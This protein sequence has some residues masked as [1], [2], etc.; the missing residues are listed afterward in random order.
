[1]IFTN[2]QNNNQ[3]PNKITVYVKN[4]AVKNALVANG[5][6]N[7][8][9]KVMDEIDNSGDI[10]GSMTDGADTVYVPAGNYTFPSSSVTEGDTIVCAPGTVFEGTTS[11]NVNGATVVGGTFTNDSGYAVSGT[12]NGTFK[13]CVFEAS[14]ALR[15]CYTNEGE[16]VV[17]ENCVFKTDFRGIHFDAMNGDVIFRNCEINGFNAFSGNGTMTFEGCT[18]GYDE[19]SYN[20]LNIYTNTTI[21][22]CTFN[23]KSGK[24]DFIDMEGTGKTLTITNC[25]ATQDGETIDIKSK[26]GGSK[27]AQNTVKVD[28]DYFVTSSEALKAAIEAK[29][30]KIVLANG[31]YSV[32]F[33]NNTSFNADNM[34]FVG[35]GDKVNVAVTSSEV[36]YGR[37]QGDN[38][39][40]ENIHFTDDVGSTGKATYNNCVFDGW[41]ICAAKNVETAFNKCTIK[42][43]L[44]T[45]S[46]FDSGNVYAKDSKIAKAEYSFGSDASAM[47]FENCEIGELISWNANTVL[48]NCT[49]TTLDDTHMT[50]NTITI[51]ESV[52]G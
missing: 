13:D 49:V 1:M 42:G 24:T 8:V 35:L 10:A 17:F 31:D 6:F 47:N 33:T 41:A 40:F 43:C 15:W 34:T 3:N 51:N 38:M 2:S 50:T 30:S 16:T 28:G 19:S 46:D 37:I 18:F 22:D 26:I 23:Y 44:N 21:K 52:V 9:I 11:L 27:L 5:T 48:T 32:R 7:G 12:V 36:W 45:S 39:T 4:E 14:E 29:A 25:V 20:G